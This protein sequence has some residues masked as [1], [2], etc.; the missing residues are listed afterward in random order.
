VHKLTLRKFLD[1]DDFLRFFTPVSDK[2][3]HDEKQESRRREEKQVRT[4]YIEWLREHR[5][6]SVFRALYA[7]NL[8]MFIAPFCFILL[9]ISNS[10]LALKLSLIVF[11][12]NFA[13]MMLFPACFT[14]IGE[15]S[16]SYKELYRMDSISAIIWLM[17]PTIGNCLLMLRNASN[18]KGIFLPSLLITAALMLLLFLRYRHETK[19]RSV[20][21]CVAAAFLLAVVM[22]GTFS[23]ASYHFRSDVPVSEEYAVITELTK[24]KSRRSTSYDAS[25]ELEDGSVISYDISSSF[26]R[27][28]KEGDTVRIATYEGLLG[29]T[30][31]VVEKAE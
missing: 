6:P 7:C 13:L 19:L 16:K 2:I 8:F 23:A 26:Y 5:N 15:K 25:L 12:I 10:S 21:T 28:S 9:G 17:T 3:V 29:S 18:A 1:D 30:F 22:L 4:E 27:N 31:T 11:G 20:M 14:T 24:N